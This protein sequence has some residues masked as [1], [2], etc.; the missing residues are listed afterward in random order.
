MISKGSII[1]NQAAQNGEQGVSITNVV[2]YYLATSAGSGVTTGTSGW[3]T[4]IQNMT[5]TNKYLWTYDKTHYSN[6]TTSTT[7]PA[8]TGVYGDSG[9]AGLSVRVT[10]WA[11]NFEY[12][13]D[14]NLNITPRYLDICIVISDNGLYVDGTGQ[15]YTPYQAKESH[16]GVASSSD[17]K[18]GSG[19]NWQIYWDQLNQLKPIYTPLL[20]SS[21]IKAEQI[22]VNNLIVKNVEV[23]DSQGNVTT[24]INGE[25]GDLYSKKATFENANVQGKVTTSIA[26]VRIELD[27]AT[28]SLK[29]YANGDAEVCVINFIS[30]GTL[31]IPKIQLRNASKVGNTVTYTRETLLRA[32]YIS[33]NEDMSGHSYMMVLNTD[34]LSFY[35]DGAQTKKY[36]SV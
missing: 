32:G 30:D 24:S 6:N 5:A 8:I 31:S 22:D 10:N 13:N 12:R 26:G 2:R 1:V 25:T 36:G 20:L 16:N 14:T 7:T 4:S 11:E 33:I 15:K 29:M 23:K 27:P 18:P 21:L 28:N 35:K 3:T 9:I 34:G 17:N 19:S